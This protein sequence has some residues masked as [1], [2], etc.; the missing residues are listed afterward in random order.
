[1]FYV[2]VV[3]VFFD[4]I[5]KLTHVAVHDTVGT[6]CKPGCS[7]TTITRQWYV[8]SVIFLR[9]P[10]VVV[11]QVS[12]QKSCMPLHHVHT[13]NVAILVLFPCDD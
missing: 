12:L 1:M 6:A 11:Y 13:I 9:K 10:A 2:P 3:L 4:S 5:N 8:R 7:G